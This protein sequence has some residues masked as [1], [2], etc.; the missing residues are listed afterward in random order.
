MKIPSNLVSEA[1]SSIT[2]VLAL[3]AGGQKSVYSAF[4]ADWG[5]VALK[6]IPLEQADERIQREIQTGKGKNF[7]HVPIIYESGNKKIGEFDFVYII[8]QFIEGKDLRALQVEGYI[9]CFEDV[10]ILL[11]TMLNT[12]VDLEAAHIVHRDIK[13]DNCQ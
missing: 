7:S 12:L 4:H 5:K 13:L 10:M 8:E 11:E 9:F 3:K 6:L 1:F 2:N